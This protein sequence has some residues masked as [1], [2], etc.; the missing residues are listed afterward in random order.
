MMTGDEA[1]NPILEAIELV[2]RLDIQQRKE[3]LCLVDGVQISLGKAA[4]IRFLESLV[5][6]IFLNF[7]QQ[8][9]RFIGLC[10]SGYD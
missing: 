2:H 1:V 5:V 9:L 6:N 7:F 8:N 10:V 3:H 4:L